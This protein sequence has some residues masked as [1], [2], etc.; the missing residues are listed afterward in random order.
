MLF[1]INVLF[2]GNFLMAPT[3]SFLETI[4]KE[5]LPFQKCAF[6]NL[7]L[8]LFSNDWVLSAG[9]SLRPLVTFVK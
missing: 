7:Q 4:L 6:I 9:R 5:K 8:S 3:I 1:E 2:D